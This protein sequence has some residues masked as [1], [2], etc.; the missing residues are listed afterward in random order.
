[1][2]QRRAISYRLS[3]VVAI[4]LLIVVT[5]ATIAGNA[6]LTTRATIDS[7]TS[8]LF[9]QVSG[10]AAEQTRAHVM[11]AV[12]AVDLLAAEL[13]GR[14]QAD[15]F[16]DDALVLE[17]ADVLRANP[18]FAWVSYSDTT[19]SFAGA[20]RTGGELR[21]NRSRIAGGKTE[22]AEHVLAADGSLAPLR[23]ADDTHYDPRTRPFYAL[24]RDAKGR[25]WTAP[26]V[27]FDQGVP[28]ITCAAPVYAKGGELRGVVTVDFDLNVLSTFASQLHLSPHSTVFLY[29][30][31]GAI[32][33]H[34]TLHVVEKSGQ[35][36]QGELVTEKNVP[37]E[38]VRE[39]FQRAPEE[40]PD[41]EGARRF[42]YEHA[43]VRYVAAERAFRI[44][45][46]LRWRVGA[47]APESD[48]LGTVEHNNRVAAGVSLAAVLVAVAIG[49]AFASRIARPLATIAQDM[50]RVGNF[51][52]EPHVPLPTIFREIAAMDRALGAMKSGL[53]SF[54][55][56]V[57]RDLVRAVLASGERA[58]LGG[59]TKTMTIF[60]SDLA[61]FTTLSETMKPA[62]LVE[63]LGGYFDEMTKVI[64][65]RGGTIDK[66]IG[67]AIMAFWNAPQDEPRHAE[68]ACEAAMACQKRLDEMRRENPALAGLTA[69]VG[70]ATGDVLVGNIG[71]RERM[72]YTVMGDTVNLASR[73]EGL[74]KAY[75]TPIMLSEAAYLASK[76]AVLAR[77][78]DVVAVKGKATGIRV[79]EP[80]ARRADATKDD[81]VFCA[82]C[83]RALDAYLA[84]DFAGAERAWGEALGVR[85][86]DE[87]ATLMQGRAAE[88]ARNAPPADWDGT[89]VMKSK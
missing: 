68:L 85:P 80:I 42:T 23:H 3:L 58:E 79:Y 86:G 28:G 40:A 38:L 39:F 56:Y 41:F 44:D 9:D 24:A 31:S 16:S 62:A 65:E 48:F 2:S 75:G 45:D 22:L 35:G 20:Y 70:V 46:R 33:A 26:Y 74:N 21:T 67:D 18:G 17:L 25:V 36:E 19:G 15:V 53:G 82:A 78:I 29:D 27:F 81:V 69:R 13:R 12:P 32:L 6:Y 72:N 66:F 63:L 84:R 5:G 1:M 43:G 87:A 76:D 88:Y 37:D 4:P 55:S 83:E 10:E 77:P 7:L 71:S 14:A 30:A 11:Q 73:L 59:K 57:P 34:P 52:I 89:H 47:V 8:Q 51:E 61:G 50:Q 49:A 64:G 60:F 54:A